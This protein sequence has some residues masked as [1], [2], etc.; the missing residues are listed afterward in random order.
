MIFSYI[1]SDKNY[2]LNN[3][4][5][6]YHFMKKIIISCWLCLLAVMTAT[7]GPVS[8]E[9][10]KAIALRSINSVQ[11]NVKGGARPG[12]VKLT[13]AQTK[14]AAGAAASSAPVPLYYVFNKGTDGGFVVVAGDDR[15]RPVLAYTDEGSFDQSKLNP[16]VEWWLEAIGQVAAEVVAGNEQAVR[17]VAPRASS[18][19][20]IE[21]LIRTEWAQG[22][23]YN[24]LCPDD[25][26][27][28]GKSLTGCVATAMAQIFYYLKY[29]AAGLGEVSYTSG[30]HGIAVSENLAD[31][32]FDYDKMELTYDADA[33]G[34]A[35]DAVAE[36]MYACGAAV[37][38]D[39]CANASG[40]HLAV[41]HLIENFGFYESC[42]SLRR[43]F[44]T[45]DVWNSTIIGELSAGRPVF[46]SAQ[47]GAQGGHAFICDG[48]DGDG[49]FHINWG[50]SGS[51]N[52]Y[53]DLMSL[54]CYDQPGT[55]FSIDQEIIYDLRPAVDTPTDDT[56]V[57][58]FY[59]SVTPSTTETEVGGTVSYS[60]SNLGAY[61][62]ALDCTIGTGLYADTEG[63]TLVSGTC[64]E[65][66]NFGSRENYTWMY[67]W[68]MSYTLPDDLADGEYYLRPVWS[69]DGDSFSPMP[70]AMGAGGAPYLVVKVSGGVVTVAEPEGFECD[71]EIE[72]TPEQ[73]GGDP[74]TSGTAE[75]TVM[76][77]NV[78]GYFNNVVCVAKT[79]DIGQVTRV[80]FKDNIV[81]EEGETKPIVVQIQMPDDTD[82]EN[83]T[84]FYEKGIGGSVERALIG[85]FDVTAEE[86][87]E[88]TP[89]LAVEGISIED[90][91]VTP[92]QKLEFTI[93]Y[94]NTGGF[95]E[96]NAMA[97]ISFD[98]GG[99]SGYS[100][101]GS[102]LSINKGERKEVKMSYD[103]SYI[104]AQFGVTEAKGTIVAGYT[105][106]STG[107]YV[108]TDKTVEF[109]VNETGE[110]P[111]P[112][113]QLTVDEVEMLTP[114]IERDEML[115][116][117]VTVSNAGGA[118][119]GKLAF[120]IAVENDDT[121]AKEVIYQDFT[122]GTDET[123]TVNVEVAIAD[124]LDK[125]GIKS[126]ADGR[127]RV[128]YVD[129]ETDETAYSDKSADFSVTVATGIGGVTVDGDKEPI[130]T[131]NGV[132][133]GTDA[134]K[135]PRGLYII[136]GK[137]VIVK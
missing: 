48:Y 1:C 125:Y 20:A 120:E 79:E 57:P 130:Y 135:L 97:R 24:N 2:Y 69:D 102:S 91:Y 33:T 56:N 99:T 30:R 15:M 78:G 8:V 23:P 107:E 35:A 39:Y 44:T 38:M 137:K 115:K 13:L 12:G 43:Q 53:F 17:S 16:A 51:L 64:D 131:V 136:K 112:A 3:Y 82:P 28:G 92:D 83:Y 126:A 27:C 31:Y 98:L 60:I 41:Y 22:S 100:D 93:T 58:I 63:K 127:V 73:T 89:E 71:V 9:Q 106:P 74:Y 36:L 134:A 128:G 80:I 50:W 19:T 59:Y 46:Y 65:P 21:P 132:Y 122:I 103:M 121:E 104:M 111:E 114:E 67:S 32:T 72:G 77:K 42:K 52:G 70:C 14:T 87:A 5:Q 116:F 29:P 95:Y 129:A 124:I 118:Y 113:P 90:A 26:G 75:Y 88:G 18:A 81:I 34:E 62:E 37:G 76:L 133:V 101:M 117:D 84:V 105:D 86:K 7:A 66:M 61:Y 10:A 108:Y 109:V 110:E 68:S 47:S 55:G 11:M 4:S 119:E 6:T 40:S 85:T 25:P 96:G 54:N 123:K 45:T 94:T 49:L